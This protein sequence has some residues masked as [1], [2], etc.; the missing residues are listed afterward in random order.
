M[1]KRYRFLFSG[2]VQG[3]GFRPFIYGVAM[4]WALSGFVRNRPDGVLVEVEGDEEAINRFLEDVR[5]DLPPLADIVDIETEIIDPQGATAFQ[6]LVSDPDGDNT[7]HLPPDTA[8]C[9]ACLKEFNDPDDRRY[10]YPFI[11]CTH[12]GP[13]LTIIRDIPYD[14]KYT[15]M[16]CFLMCPQCEAEYKNPADRRFHAEPNACPV[17]G[18]TLMLLGG[19]GQKI[20]TDDPVKQAVALIRAGHILAVKG[21]GGFHLCVDA[22]NETAVQTLRNRKYREEKPLALM[23]RDMA[24]AHAVACIDQ[25]EEQLLLSPQRPIVL[26]KKREQTVVAP[27]VAPGVGQ[28][29]IMLPYTPLHHLLLQDAPVLIMTSANQVDE[30]I[31]IGNR[32]AIEHLKGIADYFLIHNR[33][34][35]VRCDDSIAFVSA[36]QSRLIRRSRGWAPMPIPLKQSYPEVLAL[37]PHLKGTLCLLKGRHA[38]LTPHIGDMETPQARD[39]FHESLVLIKRLAESDP[40][41]IACDLHPGYYTTQLATAL[42]QDVVQVQHHHAHIV[43][44][45]AENGITGDVIGLAMDGTGY[46]PD[47]RAWG[48]EFMVVNETG[49]QR[50]AHLRYMAL[51]GGERAIREPWRIAAGLLKDACGDMWP[52]IAMDLKLV[53]D[54]TV[55]DTLNKIFTSKMNMPLASGLGRLFDGMSALIGLRRTVTFEGQAA[56]ALEAAV[57][58]SDVEPLPFDLYRDERGELLVDFCEAV[59]YTAK[60]IAMGGITRHELANRFHCSLHLA[61]GEVCQRIRDEY[62]LT[63]VVLSGGCFLNRILL[64]GSVRELRRLGFEVFTH[65]LVPTND[66]G[67]SLG[68]AIVAA[69]AVGDGLVI[70]H[71]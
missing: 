65:R 49:Y 17:C 42:S 41:R 29:G 53:A 68:Q 33:D 23:V 5:K 7:L 50:Y 44:C 26:V 43:S 32:E 58:D 52:S 48:G 19:D 3:V 38:F 63:R 47:G 66:G 4:R 71:Q 16:A 20:E 55:I 39:F 28:F 22:T 1:G 40:R 59:R 6:I 24:Q 30:P 54:L 61:F 67:I 36:G 11:N 70:S 25:K 2:T 64:E 10:R 8:V 69:S 60:F 21:L 62:D 57:D 34:I 9:A 31:C 18:P 45:M 37:G 35:L 14:R 13:R 51:P 15:S 56:M 46:G 12:C 27:G